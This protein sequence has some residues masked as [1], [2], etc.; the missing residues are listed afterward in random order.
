MVMNMMANADNTRMPRLSRMNDRFNKLH[1][2]A[3]QRMAFDHGEPITTLRR[4]VQRL[5]PGMATSY[6]AT[7]KHKLP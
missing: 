6:T 1:D 4:K 2:R 7:I 5:R 3:K